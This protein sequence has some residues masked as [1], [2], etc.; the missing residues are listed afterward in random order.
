MLDN[1]LLLT[2]SMMDK[3]NIFVT[4]GHYTILLIGNNLNY[5]NNIIKFLVQNNERNSFS[6]MFIRI[7]IA[8]LISLLS[9]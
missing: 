3:T 5:M 4:S 9:K 1:R 6:I 2:Q 8:V 7:N